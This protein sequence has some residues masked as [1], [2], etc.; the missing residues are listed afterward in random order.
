MF[1]KNIVVIAAAA[2]L[3]GG[4]AT[5]GNPKDPIEGFNRAMFS[6]NE[7]LDKAIIKP[8]AQ[9]YDYA[10][11]QPVKTGV[12]NFFGNIADVFIA[13]NNL[14]QGKLPEAASDAGRF[15]VNTTVGILGFI[16][17]ASD[18]GLEKHDEDFG[19]T[20]G[21][22]GVGPGPYV[23]IP[24]FGP[25]DARDTAGLVLDVKADPVANYSHVATRN[26]L[27]AVRVENDR[28]NLLP[29]DKVIEEAALDKYSYIRDGYLQRRRNLVYDGNP[30]R[31]IEE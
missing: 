13:V 9:G 1:A 5:S 20:F 4:C 8:V 6:F 18:M 22:W 7:G 29:A 21:R 11:P 17:V 3:L 23:V 14:L 16:D 24:F 25:R 12:T 19:Q 26:T 27:L 28:A 10:L 30:P 31:E 2:G 15:A